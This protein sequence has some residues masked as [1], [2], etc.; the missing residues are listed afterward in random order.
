M[1]RQRGFTLLELM[2]V[3]AIIGFFS[4]LMIGISSRT[5][6]ANS[7]NTA[8]QVAATLG[9]AKTRA[10]ATRR[11]HRVIIKPTELQIWASDTSGMTDDNDVSDDSFVLRTALTNGV[12]FW[13]VD[14][15]TVNAAGGQN[16][17]QD[18]ALNA[19]ISFKPDGSS[20]GGTVYLFD[21]SAKKYRLP[22][23]KVTGSTFARAGW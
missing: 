16:P 8:D 11:I 6:G 17:S 22:V 5:Y 15:S 4:A 23:Y 7:K 14:T 13:S 18:T 2:I 9:L 3:V 12:S 20:S 1:N 10:I 21:T 19:T